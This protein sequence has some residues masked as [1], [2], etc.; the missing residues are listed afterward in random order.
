MILATTNSLLLL[1][2]SH[3]LLWLCTISRSFF[4][5]NYSKLSRKFRSKLS[6]WIPSK[7]ESTSHWSWRSSWQCTRWRLYSTR[8]RQQ[9]QQQRWRWYRNDWVA[10]DAISLAQN[11]ETAMSLNYFNYLNKVAISMRLEML[12]T[13]MHHDDDFF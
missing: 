7:S 10:I 13:T 11:N 3:I 8:R 5:S 1:H 4:S 9:Q 12:E 2:I 6:E